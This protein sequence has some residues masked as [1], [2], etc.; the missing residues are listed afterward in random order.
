M[1]SNHFSPLSAR[2]NTD[3]ANE[4][5][6]NISASTLAHVLEGVAVAA[7]LSPTIRRLLRTWIQKHDR[8]YSD[9]NGWWDSIAT[10]S[11]L[12]Q[13]EGLSLLA[14]L[15]VTVV[16]LRVNSRANVEFSPQILEMIWKC[17]HDAVTYP[18]SADQASFAPSRSA[19]GFWAVPLCSRIKDGKIDELIRLHVWLPDGQRGEKATGIHAH[20]SFAQSWILAGRGTDFQYEAEVVSDAAKASHAVF[21]PRWSDGATD[22]TADGR[23]KTHRTSSTLLPT[24]KRVSVRL[25][26]METH[27]RDASYAVPAGVYHSSDVKPTEFHA[28][29]FTFD[30]SRGFVED[31]GILGPVDFEGRALRREAAGTSARE[32]AEK[33]ELHRSQWSGDQGG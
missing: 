11:V 6:D 27:G 17:V 7:K 10:C 29:L 3:K 5:L 2:L 32:L 12:K 22:G 25:A 1:G 16:Y 31:A 24:G 20:Q 15:I 19:Q 33:V 14:K 26:H 21:V 18:F 28:T 30:S 8:R 13:D 9:I 23:Y 4:V